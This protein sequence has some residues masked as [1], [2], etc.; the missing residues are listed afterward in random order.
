MKHPDLLLPYS[1]RLGDLRG[2]LAT[3]HIEEEGSSQD[4]DGNIGVLDALTYTYLRM[5]T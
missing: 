5:I 3:R 4:A 2:H 1:S